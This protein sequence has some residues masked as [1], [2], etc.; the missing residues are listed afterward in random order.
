MRDNLHY[1]EGIGTTNGISEVF[2]HHVA[3]GTLCSERCRRPQG[4]VDSRIGTARVCRRL[5]PVA[6]R[7]AIVRVIAQRSV[8]NMTARL[9]VVAD[10]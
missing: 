7:V 3:V 9:V 2:R 8:R 10:R 1:A 6:G 4:T 5:V